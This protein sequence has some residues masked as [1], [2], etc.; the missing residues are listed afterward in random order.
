MPQP[1][2]TP[3]DAAEP[4]RLHDH[5]DRTRLAMGP[6]PRSLAAFGVDPA[7]L[8][9]LPGGQGNTYTDDRLVLKSVGCVPEHDWV[10]AVYTAW[11]ASDHVRVPEPVRPGCSAEGH[12]SVDGWG[13]HVLVVGRDAAV[14]R[15]LDVIRAAGAAFHAN[16][17][18]LP[19]PGF[20]DDRD[21]P[22]AYG[23]RL[24]WEDAAPEGGAELVD[25]VERLRAQTRPV[26]LPEQPIH[27]DLL[28]NVLVS[29]GLPPAVIDWPVYHRPAAWAD[30][31]AITDAATFRGTPVEAMDA[32]GSGPDWPQLLI[33]ALLYRLGPTGFF[34]ARDSLMGSLV[35]HLERV[36][37]VARAVL[38]R[39]AG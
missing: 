24:A 28:P 2:A 15:E 32:W 9:R 3:R 38:A 18:G 27:G 7:A 34:M 36:R 25:L 31:I 16:L 19:R 33:R 8:R 35:T 10:C 37:P 30:A 11:E 22:W 29:D 6:T 21:D 12:W 14:D 1:P 23:D 26:S 5:A 17:A 39:A 13:A 4:A 20:L